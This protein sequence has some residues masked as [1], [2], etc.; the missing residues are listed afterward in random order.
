MS[1]STPTSSTDSSDSEDSYT[2]PLHKPKF[3]KKSV[4]PNA[5]QGNGNPQQELKE[6]IQQINERLDTLEYN[7]LSTAARG[8]SNE[9]HV[10]KLLK[11]DDSD[12]DNVQ[13][14]KLW[15]ERR[16][17]RIQAIKQVYIAKQL[18]IEQKEAQW[19]KRE[20]HGTAAS[21]TEHDEDQELWDFSKRS[22]RVSRV[23]E[24]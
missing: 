15:E 12:A 7:G 17:A 21:T 10:L 6:R 8:M 1:T 14:K 9:Q 23:R 24:I 19:L 20:M 2:V 11:L 3:L 5:E 13:E 22:I 18:E 16:A 4:F